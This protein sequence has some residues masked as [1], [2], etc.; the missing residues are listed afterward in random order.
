AWRTIVTYIPRDGFMEEFEEVGFPETLDH[1]Q[2]SGW[3]IQSLLRLCRSLRTF[4]MVEHEMDVNEMEQVPW[5]CTDL[6]E[7][8]VRI[9]GLDTREK[10]ES[11]IAQWKEGRKQR[12]QELTVETPVEKDGSTEARVARYLLRFNNLR[13]VWLGSKVWKTLE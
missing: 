5:Q 9:Q 8:E 2:S 3:M 1:F 6:E 13:T 11:V 7:L 4:K 10:I 12:K